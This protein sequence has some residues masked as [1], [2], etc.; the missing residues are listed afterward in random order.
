MRSWT[1]G[2]PVA[3]VSVVRWRS[4][5]AAVM[6]PPL[7]DREAVWAATGA[8][9]SRTARPGRSKVGGARGGG[10][11]RRARKEALQQL[12]QSAGHIRPCGRVRRPRGL[13][14][15]PAAFAIGPA[16]HAC[17]VLPS[18]AAACWPRTRL[19]ACRRHPAAVP[20]CRSCSRVGCRQQLCSAPLLSHQGGAG[21]AADR[22]SA[23]GVAIFIPEFQ[24]P[25][26]SSTRCNCQMQQKKKAR[27]RDA[28]PINGEP[29]A[30][31]SGCRD[32]A[33]A[34]QSAPGCR[35]RETVMD[36][37]TLRSSDSDQYSGGRDTRQRVTWTAEVR[38]TETTAVYRPW[39]GRQSPTTADPFRSAQEDDHLM[40]LVQQYGP[41]NWSAISEVRRPAA[42]ATG[43]RRGPAGP[44]SPRSLSSPVCPQALGASAHRNGKSCRLR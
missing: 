15:H 19:P 32:E 14:H 18:P 17:C 23:G 43:L 35:N 20:L 3:V 27:K 40:R 12:L 38:F 5:V 41:R 2:L 44:P 22:G 6:S 7:G 11:R 1:G 28:T 34:R 30:E 36:E 10:F 31:R 24:S 39:G 42:V 29:A 4:W 37:G 33:R 16:A 26:R 9:G 13:H 25:F 8:P 21:V